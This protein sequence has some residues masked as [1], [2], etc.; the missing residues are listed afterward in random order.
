M[1]LIKKTSAASESKMTKKSL[2]FFLILAAALFGRETRAAGESSGNMVYVYL[3]SEAKT[4]T[5]QIVLGDVAQVEGFN[6]TLIGRLNGL[7]L[8]P[9]PVPGQSC[10]IKR[11]DIRR[12]MVQHSIDP[13]NVALVGE[14]KVNVIRKGSTVSQADLTAL[15]EDYVKSSWQGED[16]RW[17]ITYSRLPDDFTL[18]AENYKLRVMN[19]I[20][21]GVTGSI[22]LSVAA[23]ENERVLERLPVSLKVR[24]FRKAA[25]MKREINQ[26]EVISPDDFEFQEQEIT[27]SR[28]E[29]VTAVKETTGKRLKRN[30]KAGQILTV[31]HLESIPLI[32]RGDEVFLIVEFKNIRVGCPGKAFQRGGMGD[33]ILVRNQYGKNLI[34]EIKDSHTVLVTP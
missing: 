4:S 34:G 22:S 27:G 24:V 26:G 8:G 2:L 3:K 14:E 13:I 1:T 29:P 18:T 10:L 7:P 23:L 21:P 11:E 30:I 17:E 9:A 31:E 6:E 15:A 28:A 16:V 19:P 5:G 32:E 20:K 25:V 33:K 12:S